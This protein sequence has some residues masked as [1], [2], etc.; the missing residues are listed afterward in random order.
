MS[1]INI[2]Q[3]GE[4]FPILLL[5][6]FCETSA[7]WFPFVAPLLENHQI[8]SAD[9]PGFGDSPILDAITI[10]SAAEAIIHQL[11]ILGIEKFVV[12]GHS[13]GGYVALA[14]AEK[15][16]SR[17]QGLGL[18]HSNAFADDKEARN[19]RDKALIFL[20]K[21]PVQKFIEPFIPSLFYEK[22]K[23]ELQQAIKRAIEIGLSS[24]AATVK[25]YTHA[26][27]NRSDRFEVWKNINVHCLFIGGMND[28]RISAQIS[29]IHIEAREKVDG[30]ILPETAHMGMYERPTETL[31]MIRDYLLKVI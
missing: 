30:Y 20:N 17:I 16:P 13:L 19:K 23:E 5:H 22:R 8:I 28:S 21:H 26:M 10:E 14:I 12:I 27:K 15:Y 29:E 2:I 6:G 3:E 18:F 9:L 11:D 1:T 7:M 31:Q 24:K 4:G 25:A